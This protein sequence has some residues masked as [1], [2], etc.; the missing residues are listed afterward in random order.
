MTAPEAV[1]TMGA[2]EMWRPLAHLGEYVSERYEISTLGRVRS[3]DHYIASQGRM[4][5][6][7]LLKQQRNQTGHSVVKLC[8]APSRTR[9]FAIHPLV[10]KTF[11]GLPPLGLEC[12]H[13]DGNPTN[14]EL[15]N[16]RWDTRS[17]NNLDRVRHGTCPRTNKVRCLR[18]HLLKMPNLL[19]G[20]YGDGHRVCL[21]CNRTRW[22]NAYRRDVGKPTLD[23]QVESDRQYELVMAN[24]AVR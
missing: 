7:R 1:T 13:N 24:E 11:C 18:G 22:K 2:T 3:K 10:L 16:L 19:R 4:W 8:I 6:G 15:S 17:N 23:I 21:S 5:R 20:E 12:C 9:T 14:N